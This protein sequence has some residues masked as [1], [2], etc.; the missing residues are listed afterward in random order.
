MAA[1]RAHLDVTGLTLRFG[2][3]VALDDVS[4]RLGDDELLAVIGPNGAGK[5]SIFN[6]LNQVY[7]PQ[8]GS[9]RLSGR[10]IVGLRPHATAAAGLARTFQNP[11]LFPQ[12]DVLDNLMVGR[13]HLMR[14]G[15]V[16]GAWWWGRARREERAERVRCHEVAELLGLADDLARPVGLLPYGTQKRVELGRALAMEPRVLLLDEPVAGMNGAERADMVTLLESV[17]RRLGLS[18]ILVEH[19]M[20]VVGRLADRVVV[21][22]F[23]RVI[24]VGTPAEVRADPAVARAYLGK[25][26]VVA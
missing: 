4:F 3:V 21:L 15:F 26:L 5:T 10:E 20:E 9:I 11:A 23:G 18:M 25:E 6:C 1:P 14:T 16:S 13:H 2:G 7:R 12:L 22:D 19:D 17:R 24:A 8:A